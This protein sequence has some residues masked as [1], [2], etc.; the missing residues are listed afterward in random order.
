VCSDSVEG[1]KP[2]PEEFISFT[3]LKNKMEG[4]E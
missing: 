4:K 3:G 2:K 1:D